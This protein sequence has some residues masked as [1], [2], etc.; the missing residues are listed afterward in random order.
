MDLYEH[1]GKRLLARYGVAVPRGGLARSPAEAAAIQHEL[2]VPVVVKAQVLS[3]GRGKAGLVRTA[4]ERDV[5]LAASAILASSHKGER[6]RSVLVE[7]RFNGAVELYASVYVDT[8]ARCRK[9]LVSAT[10]G[11][12]IEAGRDT[13]MQMPF[14]KRDVPS[15]EAIRKLWEGRGIESQCVK[16]LVA[17]TGSLI[18]LFLDTAARQVEVNPIGLV[19]GRAFAL[20]AKVTVEDNAEL[21]ITY[22]VLRIDG[23]E[24]SARALGILLVCLDGEVGIITSGAG[25]GLATID[26][27][28]VC[29][30]RAANFLDLGG[31]ATPE[32]MRSAIQLVTR[33]AGVRVLFVNVHGGLNDCELLAQGVLAGMA[34]G[35]NLPALVRMSGYHA[36]EGRRLLEAAGIP[37]AGAAPMEHCVR[38][39]LEVLS[40]RA[41]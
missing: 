33:L 28:H 13:V 36:D 8:T 9:L 41:S 21:P 25:L 16:P 14:S 1:E 32:R 17:L 24:E 19:S 37:T 23:D 27:I 12:D 2:G 11:V 20:D 40:N 7:E 15:T 18:R 3:G 31:G 22:D 29:G 4:D 35:E 39:L 5:T 10:G 6:V 34:D 38:R 26:T 30:G